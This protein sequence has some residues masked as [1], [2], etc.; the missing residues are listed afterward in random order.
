[1][2]SL[3]WKK[4]ILIIPFPTRDVSPPKNVFFRISVLFLMNRFEPADRLV[5]FNFNGTLCSRNLDRERERAVAKFG[6]P[7]RVQFGN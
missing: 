1:M 6:F 3:I 2:I 7:G 4:L 5:N